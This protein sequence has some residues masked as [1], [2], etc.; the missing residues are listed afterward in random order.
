[1]AVAMH[2]VNTGFVLVDANGNYLNKSDP[3]TTVGQ[4][5]RGSRHEHRVIPD[6]SVPNSANWPTVKRYLEL[7]AAQ[8]FVLNHM[9]QTN[10]ITY[11]AGGINSA[12]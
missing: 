10:I 1:M 4:I 2:F 6:A 5:A 9:D 3:S 12:T 11:D 8:D 7:E